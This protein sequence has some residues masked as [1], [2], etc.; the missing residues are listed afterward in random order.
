MGIAEDLASVFDEIGT[1]VE[2]VGSDPAVRENIDFSETDKLGIFAVTLR[3]GSKISIGSEIKITSTNEHYFI[4]G[5]FNE[6]FENAPVIV[7][8]RMFKAS[9]VVKLMRRSMV[10][11]PVT[12]K[13]TETW[14]EVEQFHAY[15]TVPNTGNGLNVDADETFFINSVVRVICKPTEKVEY[16]DRIQFPNAFFQVGTVDYVKYAGLC[17]LELVEDTR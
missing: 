9:H 11:D 3:S 13:E 2:I 8:G 6:I 5:G 4:S 16:L 10:K 14:A 1:E 12:R 17:A 15:V 7:S